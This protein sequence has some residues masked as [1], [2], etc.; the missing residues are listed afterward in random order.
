M[1]KTRR[2]VQE[3]AAARRRTPAVRPAAPKAGSSGASLAF[4]EDDAF[5]RHIVA[6]MRN[7]V[8]AVTRD[9]RMALI[10]DEAYRIFGITPRPGD[11]G[12]PMTEVL[13]LHPDIVRVL[14]GV[15]ELHH[16]PN[17]AEIRLKQS[18]R[19]IGYTLALV[20]NDAQELV[21]VAMFFKDLT[22]V[23]QLEERE[24]LRD[25]LVAVGELAATIAQ[26]V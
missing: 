16:L 5:F 9:G 23:E 2:L 25:R 22:R 11:L 7:G 15:F 12:R 20:R 1:A 18:E 26:E 3:P 14:S 17:R 13:H 6:G 4:I 21:G 24:R 8:L 10:N 19:V